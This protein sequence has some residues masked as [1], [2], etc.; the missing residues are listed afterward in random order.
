ME[1]NSMWTFLFHPL[2][3]TRNDLPHTQPATHK[4]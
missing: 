3:C 1:A 4:T 2:P